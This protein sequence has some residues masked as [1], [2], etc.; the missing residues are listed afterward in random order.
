MSRRSALRPTRV[1]RLAA[2]RAR[3]RARAG[4]VGKLATA[5]VLACVA[6]ATTSVFALWTAGGGGQGLGQAAALAPPANVTAVA[7]GST[8]HLTW[9]G[10]APPGWGTF[11][12]FVQRY[13]SVDAYTTPSQ[14]NG[15]CASSPAALLPAFLGTCDDSTLAVGT[16][17]YR[18]T[19]VFETW[20]SSSPLSNS[21]TVF[22][23]DHLDVSVPA[24]T[25]AG[26]PI[27][28]TITAKD[29]SNATITNYAGTVHFASTDSQATLPSDYSFVAADN[30]VHSFASAFVLRTAG[31]QHL[32]VNDLVVTTATGDAPIAVSAGALDHFV[33]TGPAAATAGMAF[34]TAKVFARDA[35]GN[36]ASGWSNVSR[37]VKFSGAGNAPDGTAPIY[38][39][40]L[41]CPVGESQLTFDGSGLASGFGLTLFN[42]A[43]IQL[44]VTA[45]GKTGTSGTIIVSASA[46][47]GLVFTGG[48][49]R[50]GAVTITC[51]G[52]VAQLIC[53]PS[54]NNEPGRERVFIASVS[55]VD[56]Y[57]N[58][59][60]T[61]GAAI[62]VTLTYTGGSALTPASLTIAAG[63]ATSSS[64]FT[65]ALQNG[66]SAMTIN[67]G[68]ILNST[69]VTVT[70]TTT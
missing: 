52:P 15:T 25:I 24:S 16:Y 57:L 8:V 56:R 18:V 40:P 6:G 26:T 61:T 38:P 53:A 17:R 48:S 35:Y 51:T 19:A 55:T 69:T 70:I 2:R 63:Q 9:V 28:A 58:T 33:V 21:T 10:P 62:T 64:S 23:L 36:I 22:L 3:S 68:A 45:T 5:I 44:V 39:A 13:S 30:G 42:A 65:A 1:E 59:A 54:T 31:D 41:V 14:T 67:A 60:A 46:A 27:G 37:C 47:A 20:T 50:N 34:T 66:S 29:A 32:R 4:R 7:S 49:N 43:P 12:Y 11:G